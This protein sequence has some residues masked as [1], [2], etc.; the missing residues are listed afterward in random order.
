MNEL[1]WMSS[2]VMQV[3]II[4]KKSPNLQLCETAENTAPFPVTEGILLLDFQISSS[5]S[6][7][8]HKFDFFKHRTFIFPL[9]RWKL[10][11]WVE[12]REED[13]RGVDL[14]QQQFWAEPR[15]RKDHD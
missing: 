5:F 3:L 14:L 1:G 2:M 12:V 11:N 6:H 10:K 15:W 9:K 7:F 4:P 8:P 13:G